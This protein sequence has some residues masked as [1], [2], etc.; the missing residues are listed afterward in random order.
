MSVLLSILAYVLR[1]ILP[2]LIQWW[3]EART[4]TAEVSAPNPARQGFRDAVL[5]SR[6]GMNEAGR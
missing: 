3:A 5:N 4:P 1:A 2:A 6:W